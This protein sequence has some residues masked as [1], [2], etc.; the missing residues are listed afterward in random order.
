VSNAVS[1]MGE[2]TVSSK[3]IADI[4]AEITAA[5]EE[6]SEGIEQVNTAIRQI[7]EMTLQN[8]ALVEQAAASES[9][10]EQAR[11]LSDLRVLYHRYRQNARRHHRTPFQRP[12]VGCSQHTGSNAAE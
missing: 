10:G 1:A 4:I 9:M 6:Q 7:D 11:N 5:S 2:I 3:K 12:A 8:A